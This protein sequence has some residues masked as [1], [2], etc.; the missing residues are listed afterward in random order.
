VNLPKRFRSLDEKSLTRVVGGAEA[1]GQLDS[2]SEL[3]E[4]ESILKTK[5]DTVRH[6]ISNIR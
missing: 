4:Q 3:G 1:K 5:H 2:K 6:P